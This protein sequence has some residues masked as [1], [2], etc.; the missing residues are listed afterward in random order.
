MSKL[1]YSKIFIKEAC[2][3]S[4]GGQAVM[5][6]IMMQG[7]DRRALAM[8]IPGTNELYLKTEK[9]P[10]K[11][12][13]EEIP[14]IRGIVAFFKSLVMGMTVLM[15]SA[16]ILEEYSPD[17]QG[18]PGK[19]EKWMDKKFGPKATWNFLMILAVIVAL[20]VT[21]LAF[22]IFPTWVVNFAGK[23]IKNAVVLNL[24]EGVLRIAIF[25]LYVL[26]ISKMQDIHTLF[27]YHGAEHKTIHC[28]ENNLELTPEN[29]AQF[30][31]LHP[32]CGTSFLM[33]VLIISL[34]LFS[35]LGW[36]NLG[37]RIASRILLLPVIAGI[38]YEL[39]KWAGRSDGA[40]VRILS[41]PGLM[42]QKLTTADPTNDQLEV[43]ILA[44]KAVLVD[45]DEPDQEGFV[46]K[47]G[48]RVKEFITEEDLPE[49]I[50]AAAAV[51]GS[52]ADEAPVSEVSA[53]ADAG[54]ESSIAGVSAIDGTPISDSAA[55]ARQAAL[56]NFKVNRYTSDI[57]TY[58]NAL[59]WG[60]SMLSMVENGR[61]DAR[62]ILTY[63]TGL[64]HAELITRG[65]ELMR[66]EDFDEYEK[67]INARLTGTPLQY[68][69][70]TQSFM[71]LP[72]RVNPSV[73]IPRL[74]TEILVERVLG[75]IGGKKWQNPE[76][77]DM[78]T[79]SGAIGISV[80]AKVP[81]AVV[82][83]TD[84]SEDALNVA[85]G[86]ARLNKVNKRCM[87]LLG[88]MFDA[89][90]EDKQYD[91]FI[92]NPPYIPTDEIKNLAI[93]V[94]EHE[95]RKALD[96]GADGLDYYRILAASAGKH[97]RRGGILA[98]EIGA[99]QAKAVTNLLDEAG[100]FGKVY[101]VKDLA[102][103]DRVIITEKI[104]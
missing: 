42:M 94:R 56:N 64:T 15:D 6:G 60:E 17:F 4:I 93:E 95:P 22:V 88:D 18:E 65:K 72:F 33:F 67:R 69:V 3:T 101:V 66:G 37:L 79:G 52:S 49:T 90:P 57:R 78:C 55:A 46:D 26:A 38:S 100:G 81:G 97:L 77:I 70:G 91:V 24:I 5:E 80:A 82:T 12:K 35:F 45:A 83:M 29:A 75:I 28:F 61:N 87:F 11:S 1:D 92:C 59:S 68:I 62:M 39:L 44:L 32:R 76:V 36:P 7:P 86:N 63:A 10:A 20:A 23:W 53:A 2:P 84:S 96:G 73:L 102:G 34:L 89:I 31:R 99:D 43:A 16:D 48:K 104:R 13:A 47:D 50:R 19:F 8:R 85:I 14:F 25:L 98:L 74:D 40:V 103:L 30:E 54:G 27:Q 51:T 71:G 21:I 9:K 41:W 58:E